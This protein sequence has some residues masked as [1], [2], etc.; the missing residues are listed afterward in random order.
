MVMRTQLQA[1][2]HAHLDVRHQKRKGPEHKPLEVVPQQRQRRRCRRRRRAAAAAAACE[3]KRT[4]E[5]ARPQESQEQRGRREE[6]VG[7]LLP[8]PVPQEADAPVGALD[9]GVEAR[10]GPKVVA[11]REIVVT[12]A[13]TVVGVAGAEFAP[14]VVLCGLVCRFV[15]YTPLYYIYI[16]VCVSIIRPSFPSALAFPPAGRG[17]VPAPPGSRRRGPLPREATPPTQQR[18][19]VS[20]A[21]FSSSFARVRTAMR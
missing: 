4:E 13:V 5:A 3:K 7:Q 21:P 12:V 19:P 10:E 17:T 16:Y 15:N 8:S 11:P 14:A 18:S 2:A 6:E 20:L 1:H 9:V